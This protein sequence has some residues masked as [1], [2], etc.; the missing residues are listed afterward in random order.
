MDKEERMKIIKELK[1]KRK[2][3]KVEQIRKKQHAE[4]MRALRVMAD[5][6]YERN[7]LSRCGLQ[8]LKKLLEIK[9]DN[10]EKARAHYRFQLLK[11]KFLKWMFYTEDMWIERNYKAEDFYRKKILRRVFEAFKTVSGNIF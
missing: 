4:R 5:L 11:N 9:R 7:L 3:E 10:E 2:R 6:H 1:E 8:P